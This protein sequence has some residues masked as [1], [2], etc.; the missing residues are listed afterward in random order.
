[1]P[2]RFPYC[3]WSY[4]PNNYSEVWG[5]LEQLDYQEFTH[6]KEDGDVRLLASP[7][8]LNDRL[9]MTELSEQYDSE[10]Q[11]T[12]LENLNMLYVAFTRAADKLFVLSGKNYHKKV[13]G[14]GELMRDFLESEGTFN[15]E[16]NIYEINRGSFIKKFTPKVEVQEVI[17]LPKI[18]SEDRSD[19]LR[20]RRT[21]D[22]IFDPET[23]DK[24]KDRGNKVHEAFAKIKTKNDVP[25]A[26]QALEF[27]GIITQKE[28]QGI[29]EAIEKVINLPELQP[30]FEEGLQINNERE[31][32][33]PN[34]EIQR[35]DRVVIKDGIVHIIDYKTG[36]SND[37]KLH[38]KY[39]EQVKN[40]GKLYNQMGYEKVEM[41]LVYLEMNEVV[42]V[43]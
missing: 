43:A 38:H 37:P 35:P 19:R 7:I 33:L 6:E 41:M 29:R 3:Q 14:V 25:K 32:L 34:G 16:E 26:I 28:G 5:D 42:R 8:K 1:M 18:I 12:F 11:A 4:K 39:A 20:L 27:E 2:L 23:L 9:G 13:Q 22:K 36:K 10:M 40:Y 24:S 30:L 31:I 21:S 17:L 15:P